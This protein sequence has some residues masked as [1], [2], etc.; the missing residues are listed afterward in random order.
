MTLWGGSPS[1][2]KESVKLIKNLINDYDLVDVWRLRNPTYKKFSWRCT[3]PVTMRRFDFFLV[4]DIMELD[5]SGCGFFAP[6][7][8]DHS[9]IFIKISPLQETGRGPGYWKFYS[10]LVNDP[11]FVEKT[12]EIN[13]EVAMN[14]T[15]Q[16]E[17]Y[18]IGWEF[19]KYNVRQFSQVYSKRK[20]C[21]RW[22][23]Q[24]NLKEKIEEL[25]SSLSE[26]S[27]PEE[28]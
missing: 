1:L 18:R 23:K 12:K 16:F 4:S 24:A 13:N 5:I 15:N 27:A 22:E 19:L 17:D 3:K 6:V 14:I 2:K 26:N 25:E 21:E 20:A 8:S 28:I 11:T 10:S 9:P 7:Q